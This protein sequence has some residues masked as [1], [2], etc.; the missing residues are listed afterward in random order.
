MRLPLRYIGLLYGRLD[1]DFALTSGVHT[2]EDVVKAIMAGANAAMMASELLENGVAW[3]GT[4]SSHV[5]ISAETQSIRRHPL[6]P[7]QE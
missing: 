4:I 6:R 5:G 1:A 7:Y 3:I 2:H